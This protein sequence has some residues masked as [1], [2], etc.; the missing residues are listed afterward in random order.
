LVDSEEAIVGGR[1]GGEVGGAAEEV[2]G[3]L[4]GSFFSVAAVRRRAAHRSGRL[5]A[6]ERPGR[7]MHLDGGLGGRGTLRLAKAPDVPIFV[8]STYPSTQPDC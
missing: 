7:P 1:G 6:A 2:V 8:P 5:A 3:E 4:A